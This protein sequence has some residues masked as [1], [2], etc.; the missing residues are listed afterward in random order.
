MVS[1]VSVFEGHF[2]T[3]THRV[4]H[5]LGGGPGAFPPSMP[6]TSLTKPSLSCILFFMIYSREIYKLLLAL[7]PGPPSNLPGD[8]NLIGE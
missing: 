4:S 2:L 7:S 1:L 3:T 5:A 6:S 8:D